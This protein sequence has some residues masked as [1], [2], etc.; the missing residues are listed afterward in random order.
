MR[1]AIL[2]CAIFVWNAITSGRF[3]AA[4]FH[5]MHH[6]SNSAIGSIIAFQFF[7][8]SLVSGWGGNFADKMERLFPLRGRIQV[9]VLGLTLG[10]CG[11][12][13]ES[14]VSPVGYQSF[15]S[16]W[17]FVEDTSGGSSSS[18]S[19]SKEAGKREQ[20]KTM[21]GPFLWHLGW[22]TAYA[23]SNTLVAPVLDGLTLAHLKRES[24]M[25]GATS[26]VE[27]NKYGRERLHGAIWWGIGNLI[28][29]ICIDKW[30]YQILCPLSIIS[31]IVCYITIALYYFC[32]KDPNCIQ[33]PEN[34]SLLHNGTT[35]GEE[36]K[37]QDADTDESTVENNSPRRAKGDNNEENEVVSMWSLLYL[38]VATPYSVGFFIA[39][40]V[41]SV[42]FTVVENLIF[43]FY[44][45][46]LGSSSTMCVTTY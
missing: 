33:S 31:T 44:Q 2:Y 12:L 7:T 9:L 30:G 1:P 16:L 10:T 29:G 24:T 36:H 6:L 17:F 23:V 40:F 14:M 43:L 27:E 11:F 13:I 20:D 46:V 35:Q 38:L 3:I 37:S 4:Q 41:L 32:L 18:S 25:N 15:H 26:P 45:S 39:Y 28:I 8:S 42:G 5:N 34:L 19:S 21:L 22:R